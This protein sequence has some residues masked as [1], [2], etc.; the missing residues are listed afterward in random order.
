M[1]SSEFSEIVAGEEECFDLL[2]MEVSRQSFAQGEILVDKTIFGPC[3]AGGQICEQI[4][5]VVHKMAIGETPGI[6]KD[7][8]CL[9]LTQDNIGCGQF[10]MNKRELGLQRQ[11]CRPRLEHLLPPL[12]I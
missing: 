3:L 12:F 5:Q 8:A 2:V 11:L 1:R 7:R 4:G 10:A 9:G 6:N